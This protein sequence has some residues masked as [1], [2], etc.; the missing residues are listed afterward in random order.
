[1]TINYIGQ[2]VVV[3][4]SLDELQ[5]TRNWSLRIWL[6]KALASRRLFIQGFTLRGLSMRRWRCQCIW[7]WSLWG[8]SKEK[9]PF[10]MVICLS[11]EGSPVL[12]TLFLRN[13]LFQ[14][15]A[16]LAR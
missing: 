5:E 11:P 1:M 12:I 16:L 14:A 10:C 6:P 4:V 9:Q 2:K 8:W 3:S 15:F 7:W 13:Q